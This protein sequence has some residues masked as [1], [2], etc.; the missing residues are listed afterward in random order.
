MC[1]KTTAA[2]CFYSM[3][4]TDMWKREIQTD[5]IEKELGGGGYIT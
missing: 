4:R 1:K 5:K 2:Y 3:I